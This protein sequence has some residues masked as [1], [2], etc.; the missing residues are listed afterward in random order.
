M[1]ILNRVGQNLEPATDTMQIFIIPLPP[2]HWQV[3]LNQVSFLFHEPGINTGRIQEAKSEDC[4]SLEPI[5]SWLLVRVK[6][7]LT[8]MMTSNDDL[9]VHVSYMY[10]LNPSLPNPAVT[11]QC[12]LLPLNIKVAFTQ[13]ICHSDRPHSCDIKAVDLNLTSH[14][15]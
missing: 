5:Y 4:K 9:F 13:C 7:K 1:T 15:I 10:S 11:L 3:V 8:V 12:L 6:L 14:H 2:K